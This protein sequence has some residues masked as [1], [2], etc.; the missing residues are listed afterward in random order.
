MP[1]RTPRPHH[2][3]HTRPIRAHVPRKKRHSRASPVPSPAPSN[4]RHVPSLPH[5]CAISPHQSAPTP[6]FS[7]PLLK[8]T[9]NCTILAHARNRPRGTETLPPSG[10][11]P[12]ASVGASL[13]GV[14]RGSVPLY[15]SVTR[16]HFCDTEK[17]TGH[18]RI[19]RDRRRSQLRTAQNVAESNRFRLTAFAGVTVWGRQAV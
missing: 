12:Q 8:I 16:C 19:E 15:Y 17:R 13:V 6:Q 10:I 11:R 2:L 1:Q 5:A 14:R 3:A 9:H 4:P 7:P 18:Y